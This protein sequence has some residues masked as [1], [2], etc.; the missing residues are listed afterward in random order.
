MGAVDDRGPAFKGSKN[1]GV[2]M[3]RFGR[4]AGPRKGADGRAPVSRVQIV[5]VEDLREHDERALRM[6]LAVQA[7]KKA[8]KEKDT[9]AQGNLDR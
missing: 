8:A 2:A 3:V 4:G 7:F 1:V 9:T 5:T 6:P